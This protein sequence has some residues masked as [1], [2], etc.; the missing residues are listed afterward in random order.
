MRLTTVVVILLLAGCGGQPSATDT[1]DP[2]ADASDLTPT[3]TPMPTDTP[4]PPDNPYEADPVIVGIDNPTNR[5]YAPLVHKAVE[6]WEEKDSQ[7]GD[8]TANYQIQPDAPSPDI[9]IRFVDKIDVCGTESGEDI[10]GCAPYVNDTSPDEPVEVRIERGKRGA[11]YNKSLIQTIKHEFGHLY[12]IEHGEEPMP[13]MNDTHTTNL[14]SQPNATERAIPWKNDTIQIYVDK[15]SF[16]DSIQPEIDTQ[17]GNTLEWFNDG[18]GTTPANFTIERTKNRSEAEIIVESGNA[19]EGSASTSDGAYGFDTD[20]DGELEYYT[21]VTVVIDTR[22]NAHDFGWHI[23]Y[24]TDLF[25]NPDERSEQFADPDGGD[26][27]D[28]W[29]G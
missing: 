13:L 12:G 18:K 27:R 28:W 15:N 4:T 26:R 1:P 21:N 7:Y 8:Y 22:V 2:T 10:V 3:A 11:T 29:E 6:Y 16:A 19:P 9:N 5:S 20:S 23:G 17:V 25:V 24:W 14:T